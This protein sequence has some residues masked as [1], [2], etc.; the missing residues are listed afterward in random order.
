MLS[1][2]RGKTSHLDIADITQTLENPPPS[3]EISLEI[4]GIQA[5]YTV[6][7]YAPMEYLPKSV[8]VELTKKAVLFDGQLISVQKPGLLSNNL[9]DVLSLSREYIGRS[10]AHAAV[11]NRLVQCI[12]LHQ[13][14]ANPLRGNQCGHQVL[15]QPEV[16]HPH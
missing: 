10:L 14:P 16:G 6:L 11:F 3:S 8:R 5:V 4:C 9:M 12:T 13:T 15:S 2:L 1:Y 7:R